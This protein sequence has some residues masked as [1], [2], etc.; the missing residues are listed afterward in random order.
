MYEVPKELIKLL[1]FL[2][3]E[4]KEAHGLKIITRKDYKGCHYQRSFFVSYVAD[5]YRDPQLT[6]VMTIKDFQSAQP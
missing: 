1:F 4:R 3:N 6:Q 5:D 2:K